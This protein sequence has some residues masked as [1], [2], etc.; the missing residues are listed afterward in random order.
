MKKIAVVG[1]GAAGM[2][3]AIR[4]LELGAKVT[5]F[6][7]NE[8]LGKKIYITGKGR[9]NVT[10][11]C[12]AE[13]FF[14]HLT[15][16]E[17]F[18]YSAYYSFDTWAVQKLFQDEGCPLKVERGNRVF[19]VSDHSSDI[20]KALSKKLERLGCEIRYKTTVKR[21]IVE[22]LEEPDREDGNGK[23]AK[24]KSYRYQVKG[25]VC[26]DGKKYFY[27]AVIL[28]TGGLSYPSTGSTGDGYRFVKE[29][30]MQIIQ[31]K[32]ALVPLETK[33][34][35]A[36]ALQGLSL[37]NVAATLFVDGKKV[38]SG[39][40]E[41]LFTHF[42]VSGPL[43]LTASSELAKHPDTKE[44]IVSIDLKPALEEG[45]FD[46][47]LLREFEDARNK[48]LKNI[49][50]GVYPIRLAE[51]ILD[52]AGIDGS[53][54]A[55]SV[56]REQ[57]EELVNITKNLTLT[58]TGTRDFKEAIITSGGISVKEINPST[59]ESRMVKK[60]YCAG[61]LLDVDAHT[62]GFNLQIAWSTGHLAGESAAE[63]EKE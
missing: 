47:R 27:D 18:M 39:Q 26:A 16:N 62:G 45:Q 59:M 48:Q 37:K 52:I 25:L 54:A 9:C 41:M 58:I 34:T 11:D 19:P 6:E 46:K 63:E 33:E 57:R 15:G 13:T 40:G 43:I 4:A 1:G 60:L 56:T 14:S 8:K 61:E 22:A 10:N 5:L 21:L 50:P 2:I 24:K 7:K 30:G 29:F 3:A 55:H 42:G 51:T 53:T 36:H 49:L 31:P 23:K 32:P 35:W 20:I 12:D 17:K 38:Y 44:C 28:A